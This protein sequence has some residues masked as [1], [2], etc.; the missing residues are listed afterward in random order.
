M[1][2][3]GDKF[4]ESLERGRIGRGPAMLLAAGAAAG[5]LVLF[6]EALAKGY[7]DLYFAG[8]LTALGCF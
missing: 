4:F 7:E 1:Q 5:L 8:L 2:R 6:G 3:T